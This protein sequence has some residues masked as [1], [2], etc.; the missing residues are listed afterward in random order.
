MG[1]AQTVTFLFETRGIGLAD[2]E[3][4][5][6]TQCALTMI[7]SA[8]EVAAANAEDVYGTIEAGRQEF[9]NSTTPIVITDYNVLENTTYQMIWAAN[10]SLVDVP[11][12]F[13]S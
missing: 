2:Q 7:T 6:R 13:M 1:L 9:I 12:Q 5:R 8:L 3:F 11:V 4:R 10:G